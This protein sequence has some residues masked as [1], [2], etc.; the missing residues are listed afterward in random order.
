[1]VNAFGNVPGDQVFGTNNKEGFLNALRQASQSGEKVI[2]N[3]MCHGAPNGSVQGGL[4]AS[5]VANA[6]GG[7]NPRNFLFVQGQC[8]AC[9]GLAQ[10]VNNILGSKG[11]VYYVY[12]RSGLQYKT[13]GGASFT[14]RNLLGILQGNGKGIQ[15]VERRIV[16]AARSSFDI[17][18]TAIADELNSYYLLELEDKWRRTQP[19]HYYLDADE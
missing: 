12:E 8:Y 9:Q 1:M 10:Q 6:I 19:H 3:I 4:N 2:V 16:R 17:D 18:F 14:V 7:G 15:N 11:G 13:G 5:D